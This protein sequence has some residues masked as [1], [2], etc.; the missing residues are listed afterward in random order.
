MLIGAPIRGCGTNKATCDNGMLDGIHALAKLDGALN[1]FEYASDQASVP[2]GMIQIP[3]VWDYVGP[4]L[5][6]NVQ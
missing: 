6:R 3:T 1:G 4:Y 2:E 5:W